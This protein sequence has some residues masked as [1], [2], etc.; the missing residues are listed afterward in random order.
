MFQHIFPIRGSILLLH[1]KFEWLYYPL[2]MSPRAVV[3]WNTTFLHEK[4]L[5]PEW[6]A[7]RSIH[8]VDPK[9]LT[10]C[11]IV[12]IRLKFILDGEDNLFMARTF[13]EDC[14]TIAVHV[15]TMPRILN[16]GSRYTR[17]RKTWIWNG[18]G[19][20]RDELLNSWL[21]RVYQFLTGGRGI[22]LT[23]L[24]S[25]S[26]SFILEIPEIAKVIIDM[27]IHQSLVDCKWYQ[28]NTD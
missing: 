25:L 2:S 14:G 12:E 8:R 3:N 26:A 24:V 10:V 23:Y 16:L 28:S 17:G 9:N 7:I 1:A 13:F 22:W 20:W 15:C 5:M 19:A 6:T 4:S 11:S 18:L 21:G 27:L